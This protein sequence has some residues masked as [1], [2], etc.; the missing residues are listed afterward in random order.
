[1]KLLQ[2]H[3]ASFDVAQDEVDFSLDQMEIRREI[4][5]VLSEVEGCRIAM[6]LNRGGR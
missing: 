2:R 5:L 1:M 4:C 3:P 6:Q